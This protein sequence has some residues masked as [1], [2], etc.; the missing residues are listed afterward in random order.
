MSGIDLTGMHIGITGTA[1][2]LG[3]AVLRLCAHAGA[4]I[5]ALDANGGLGKTVADTV[6]SDTGADVTFITCDVANERSVADAFEVI[7]ADGG[8]LDGVVHLAGIERN[9]GAE[10]L[11]S[12]EVLEMM[13][14]NFLGTVYINQAAFN[15]MQGHGGGR[16]LNT[17]SDSALDG[18]IGAAHYAASKA[19]VAVW[20]RTVAREWGKHGISVN[21]LAPAAWTPM[22]DSHR[23]RMGEEELNA[24]DQLMQQKIPL[25]GK[26]GSPMQDVAPVITFLMAPQSRFITGQI[27]AVNGGKAMVR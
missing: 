18:Q 26:L 27:I 20:T 7:S 25:G 13:Q 6:V 12:S 2:G 21:A 3:E 22:Y 1:Q 15:L 16:I 19:A 11:S 24:H 10:N 8:R 9:G 23:E 5:F 4:K 14:V 17:S